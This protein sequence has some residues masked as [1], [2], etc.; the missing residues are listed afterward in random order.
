MIAKPMAKRGATRNQGFLICRLQGHLHVS[1]DR[2]AEFSF[3]L[4]GFLGLNHQ[5]KINA[6]SDIQA[7]AL[8]VI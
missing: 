6:F 8:L 5:V 2:V 4:A 3:C 1:L 7:G